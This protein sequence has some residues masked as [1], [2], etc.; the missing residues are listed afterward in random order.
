MSPSCNNTRAAVLECVEQLLDLDHNGQITPVEVAVALQTTFVFVPE[1]LT[2]QLVMRCDL[3][4]DG[5]LTIDDWNANPM[6]I[7]C[8]PTQNCINIA[9]S[10]CTQNGF[11]QTKR[12]SVQP[13]PPLGVPPN[14]I[15]RIVPKRTPE[16]MRLLE[17]EVALGMKRQLQHVATDKD[18][19]K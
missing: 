13:T 10:V 12:Q 11:V 16:Q 4:E 14:N 8:L 9:C 2:W 7:T 5:V 1:W 6:N 15:H 18:G 19:N 17:N 3:D